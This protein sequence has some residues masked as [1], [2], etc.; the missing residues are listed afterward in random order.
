MFTEVPSHLTVLGTG[1][2]A[3][4]CGV[5]ISESVCLMGAY[6]IQASIVRFVIGKD[7]SW[8]YN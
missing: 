8:N 2:A 7:S 3:C 4:K 6:H 5:L 1:V